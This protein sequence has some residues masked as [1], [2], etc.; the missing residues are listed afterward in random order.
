ML[1]KSGHI[2]RSQLEKSKKTP[3]PRLT[4]FRLLGKSL[5]TPLSPTP[6]T[7]AQLWLCVCLGEVSE[8][9]KTIC[10]NWLNA[11]VEKAKQEREEKKKSQESARIRITMGQGIP[12][13]AWSVICSPNMH[14]FSSIDDARKFAAQN[15]AQVM[16]AKKSTKWQLSD[17]PEGVENVVTP[18]GSYTRAQFEEIIRE[19][20]ETWARMR[21]KGEEVNAKW[22]AQK[23]ANG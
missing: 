1:R 19:L 22:K 9:W 17:I 20:I 10:K 7:S 12:A 3:D 23:K 8:R 13:F 21:S 11:I 2:L 16:R 6:V 18:R 4:P 5:G 14:L 15:D